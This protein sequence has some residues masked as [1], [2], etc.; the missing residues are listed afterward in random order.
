MT[1]VYAGRSPWYPS[2]CLCQVLGNVCLTIGT[3]CVRE[4][5]VQRNPWVVSRQAGR[6]GHVQQDLL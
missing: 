3:E 6:H 1:S 2:E 4:G 5:W